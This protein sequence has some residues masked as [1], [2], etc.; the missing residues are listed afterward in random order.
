LKL[1]E[2]AELHPATYGQIVAIYPF[3]SQRIGETA[4]RVE[5]GSCAGWLTG[6]GRKQAEMQEAPHKRF[7]CGASFHAAQTEFPSYHVFN[8]SAL[9]CG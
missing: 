3:E 7:L 2:R 8:S 1:R 4:G 9:A 5:K 6:A